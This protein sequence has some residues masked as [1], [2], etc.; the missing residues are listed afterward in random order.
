MDLNLGRM[1]SALIITL[2]LG[3]MSTPRTIDHMIDSG[4]RQ[5]HE[6]NKAGRMLRVVLQYAAN[7]VNLLS[8]RNT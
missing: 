2:I 7:W 3:P 6:S 4:A 1:E 8:L 5:G